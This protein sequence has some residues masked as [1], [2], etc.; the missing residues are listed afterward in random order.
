LQ[1]INKRKKW[2]SLKKGGAKKRKEGRHN[3]YKLLSCQDV[4]KLEQVQRHVTRKKKKNATNWVLGSNDEKCQRKVVGKHKAHNQWKATILM[5]T[6]R[7]AQKLNI[8]KPKSSPKHKAF[9][10]NM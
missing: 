3:I 10:E 2:K 9:G 4:H 7:K 1:N 5:R 6:K 8:L